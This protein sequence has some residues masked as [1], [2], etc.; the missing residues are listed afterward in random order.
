MPLSN[1]LTGLQKR[2]A[3]RISKR[4]RQLGYTQADLAERLDVD[5]ETISRFERGLHTPPVR[6]LD[7]LAKHLKMTLSDLLEGYE[8][9]PKHEVNRLLFLINDLPAADR[10]FLIQHIDQLALH[11]RRSH[12][13]N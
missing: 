5:V 6:T 7:R 3:V 2:M 1:R 11:L 8:T 13:K 12:Q 10:K 4:R 9:Q